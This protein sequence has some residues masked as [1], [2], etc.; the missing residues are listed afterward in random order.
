MT[1]THSP[2][3]KV[4]GTPKRTWVLF[5]NSVTSL[6]EF[7]RDVHVPLD[8]EF[9]VT[10]WSRNTEAWITEVYHIHRTLPLQINRIGNWSSQTGIVWSNRTHVQRRGDLHGAV[11]KSGFINFVSLYIYLKYRDD[12]ANTQEVAGSISY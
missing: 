5:Y 7:F 1:G 11:I 2:R 6:G 4:S 8:S 9:L 12:S 3:P 10:Q